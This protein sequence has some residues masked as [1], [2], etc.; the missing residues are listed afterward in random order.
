[1]AGFQGF[2]VAITAETQGLPRTSFRVFLI[3]HCE[4]SETSTVFRDLRV[5]AA[6]ET[7]KPVFLLI[8]PLAPVPDTISV[9][10]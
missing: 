3:Y 8:S 5:S 2:R 4:P 6:I 10:A 7:W 9:S 1:M